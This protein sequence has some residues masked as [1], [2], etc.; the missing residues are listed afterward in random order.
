MTD[1]DRIAALEARLAHLEALLV[2]ATEDGLTSLLWRG[3]A[4]VT[5]C[6]AEAE[7]RA[8]KVAAVDRELVPIRESQAARR[9]R[10][11]RE[12]DERKAREQ[13][14]REA[15][16]AAAAERGRLVVDGPVPTSLAP[17][18]E[19]PAV[20]TA[21][22]EALDA[23]AELIKRPDEKLRGEATVLLVGHGGDFTV[24]IGRAKHRL[25]GIADVL[26]RSL[27]EQDLIRTV[28]VPTKDARHV[29]TMAAVPSPVVPELLE[30]ASFGRSPEGYAHALAARQPGELVVVYNL[31]GT[32]VECFCARRAIGAEPLTEP[33]LDAAAE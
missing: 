31:G 5:T 32:G 23:T 7:R 24:G 17:L 16:A 25:S 27:R 9:E 21:I 14:E 30:S 26:G 18:L 10:E 12:K 2:P 1:K 11:R 6:E 13:A 22:G 3:E 8:R 33:A 28:G 29:L 4:P 19:H 20:M 15:R